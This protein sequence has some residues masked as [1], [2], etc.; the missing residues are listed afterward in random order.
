MRFFELINT[1][2]HELVHFLLGSFNLNW[3]KLHDEDHK[4]LTHEIEEYL[5]D[6]SEVKELERLV[7]KIIKKWF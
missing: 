1:I 2:S 3:A 7:K 6:L 5:W 4:K